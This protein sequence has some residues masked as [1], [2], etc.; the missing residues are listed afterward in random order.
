MLTTFDGTPLA[1]QHITI[2]LTRTTSGAT[3]TYDVVTDYTGTFTLPI[4]LA[5]GSYSAAVS[6]A[7]TDEY[8]PEGTD[9]VPIE[10]I[11]QV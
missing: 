6:Y 1:G 5:V 9:I 10:V 3:K 8:A 2:E 11:P 4:N 7:G